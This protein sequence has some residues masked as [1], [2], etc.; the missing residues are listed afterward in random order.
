[1]VSSQRAG[2]GWDFVAEVDAAVAL[3]EQAPEAG[4]I[5]HRELRRL[6][7]HRFPYALYYTLTNELIDVRAVLHQRTAPIRWRERA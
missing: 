4:P 3:L 7:L 6:L 2:L 1:V 5:V